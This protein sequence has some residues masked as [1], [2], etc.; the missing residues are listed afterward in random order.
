[1][2][3]HSRDIVAHYTHAYGPLADTVFAGA[4]ELARLYGTEAGLV[5]ASAHLLAVGTA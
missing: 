1:M 4:L 5:A 3:Q 2:D